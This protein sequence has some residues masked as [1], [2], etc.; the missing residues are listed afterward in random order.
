MVV[1]ITM[2]GAV[3]MT[4][5]VKNGEKLKQIDRFLD[6]FSITKYYTQYSWGNDDFSTGFSD[7]FHLEKQYAKAVSESMIVPNH[8]R[9]LAV[10]GNLSKEPKL[11]FGNFIP[12]SF[13]QNGQ[14]SKK[15]LY[16]PSF[17][18]SDLDK[19]IA[20]FGPTFISKLLR[21]SLPEYYGAIDTRIV[22][23]FGTGGR[24]INGKKW[25]DLVVYGGSI[26]KT[27]GWQ[28]EYA[29][30][31]FILRYITSKLNN[32]G[33]KC[34]HP[35]RFVQDGLRENGKWYCADVEMALYAYTHE[36][37]R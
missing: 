17:Y 32:E 34:P 18:I 20:Y 10:W 33:E 13:F 30:W 29:A 36:V 15:V 7:I 8:L 11:K 37:L 21:F 5:A 23:V 14:I 22:S 2:E 25:I 24:G 1:Q 4:E 28:F 31:I 6:D 16:D 9:S 27:P 3:T 12:L 26:S 19:R 35:K